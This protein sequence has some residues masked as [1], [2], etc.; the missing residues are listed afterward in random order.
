MVE[1]GNKETSQER[2]RPTGNDLL[3]L[4]REVEE[5]QKRNRLITLCGSGAMSLILLIFI[6]RLW[7]IVRDYWLFFNQLRPETLVEVKDVSENH[8]IRFSN[9]Q[10]GHAP[11]LEL[12]CNR[13]VVL[14]K[15]RLPQAGQQ[16]SKELQTIYLPDFLKL[17]YERLS[18]RNGEIKQEVEKAA[19]ALGKHIENEVKGSMEKALDKSIAQ[20]ETEIK[21]YFPELDLATFRNDLQEAHPYLWDK[22][23]ERGTL[24]IARF[25]PVLEAVKGQ[26]DAIHR[27]HRLSTQDREKIMDEFLAALCDRLKYEL[28]PAMGDMPAE[29]TGEPVQPETT[30]IKAE[31][32]TPPAEA[33]EKKE[34]RK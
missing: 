16:F 10:G 33:T 30:S 5:L 20:I 7:G 9:Y 29:E 14:A 17:Y 8:P 4:Y 21:K 31:K 11:K 25:A 34:V 23:H 27:K 15:Q 24:R 2:T 19:E 3:N 13:I 12:A 32:A 18:A 26:A 1:T 28:V 6:F 22:L